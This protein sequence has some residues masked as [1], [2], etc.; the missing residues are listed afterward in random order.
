MCETGL[1]EKADKEKEMMVDEE[2]KN[3][4]RMYAERLDEDEIDLL[5]YWRIIWKRRLMISI[6][7][8]IIVMT[9]AIASLFMKDIY[10]AR[11]VIIPVSSE[12]SGGSLSSIASQFGGIAGMAGISMPGSSST[13]EIIEYLNSNA[14][15]EKVIVKYDLLPL[16]FSDN[17]DKEK[18]AWKEP[19]KP[20]LIAKALNVPRSAIKAI[21][22]DKIQKV[23]GVDDSVPT[24]W[25]GL[26]SLNDVVNITSDKKSN[27][28]T[29]SAI[30]DDPQ[31][32]AA[33]VSYFIT[34]LTDHMSGE[35][36]R[37]A[38]ANRKHL[39]QQ[40]A[41]ASDPIIRQKIYILLSQQVETALMSEVKENF[42][43]KVIDPPKAPDKKIKP[44]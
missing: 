2:I 39:E 17:W 13:T 42:A 43:F 6:L 27:A 29:I 37:V 21:K 35:S 10:E 16:L 30:I 44:R 3:N 19:K 14:L 26:R 33:I 1:F 31:N 8:I 4:S 40:L 18:K 41:K 36:K 22:P 5:E 34:S 23:E 7:T 28:I 11:A 12:K 9:T 25:D 32:A 24:I 15:R 20:G 38:E